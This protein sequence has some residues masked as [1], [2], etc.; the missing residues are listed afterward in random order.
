MVKD[1]SSGS[2]NSKGAVMVKQYEEKTAELKIEFYEK[3]TDYENKSS[4]KGYKELNLS[5]FINKGMQTKTFRMDK[6][7]HIFLTVN[8]TVLG[9]NTK[10]D[11]VSLTL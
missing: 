4:R 2:E 7:G 3:N 9:A 5:E 1:A 8:I 6:E 11:V 10:Q